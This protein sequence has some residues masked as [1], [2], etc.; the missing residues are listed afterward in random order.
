[1]KSDKMPHIIHAD[2]ESLTRKID[3]CKNNTENYSTTKIVEHIPCG[4]WVSSTWAFYHIENKDTLYRGEDCMKKFC[5]S[6]REHTKNIINFEKNKMLPL[7]KKELKSH[8]N[9]K[10]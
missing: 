5:K 10:V 6:L 2:I 7:T 4:Y 8:Q 9:A 3:G 1:M